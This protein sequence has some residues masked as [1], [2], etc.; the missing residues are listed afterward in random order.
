MYLL[1]EL[2][3]CLQ[4]LSYSQMIDFVSAISLLIKYLRSYY[5]TGFANCK[6]PIFSKF[7]FCKKNLKKISFDSSSKPAQEMIQLQ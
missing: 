3:F 2:Q 7:Q 5:N 4:A 6:Y 1:R